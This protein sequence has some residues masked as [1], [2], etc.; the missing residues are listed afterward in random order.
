MFQDAD[1]FPQFGVVL[2]GALRCEYHTG[3]QLH[4]AVHPVAVLRVQ[5]MVVGRLPLLPYVVTGGYFLQR[6]DHSL[7]ESASSFVDLGLFSSV[8]TM[9]ILVPS[10][11]LTARPSFAGRSRP[12][13]CVGCSYCTRSSSPRTHGLPHPQMP[14]PARHTRAALTAS[15]GLGVG[16]WCRTAVAPSRC[17]SRPQRCARWAL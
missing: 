2:L 10:T 6:R 11:T 16:H 17:R 8:S 1:L 13:R 15:P 14:A 7:D 12:L 9:A 3:Q 5:P 4:A